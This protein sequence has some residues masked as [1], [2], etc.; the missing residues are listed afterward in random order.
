MPTPQYNFTVNLDDL[1][2]ILKQIKIAEASTNPLT[3]AIENLR[4]LVGSPLL[5]Y[6]LRTVDGSWNS[7]L[8]G[9]ER[10][11]AADNVMPRLV[12]GV[13]HNAEGRPVNLFGL[14][15]PGSAGSSY[16]QSNL[17]NVVYDSQPRL[18]SNLIVD[19]TASNP[20][21]VAAALERAANATYPGLETVQT[22]GNGTLFI[23]NQSPDIG[24]SA[25]FSGMMALFGQ[26]FDHGLDLLTK[27]GGTV[28]VPLKTDD[29]LYVEGSAT[30]FM[31]LSRA[32]NTRG[33]GQDGILGNADDD[34]R[35]HTNTTT[36]F[37]DQNQTYT[38][39]PSHQVFLREYAM[40][41]G[42]P[43]A[44]GDMLTGAH[45]IGNW[46]ELK[47]QAAQMLGICLLDADVGSVPLLATDRYGAFLRGPNG[48]VQVVTASGLIEGDPTANGGTGVLLPPNTLR[49]GHEFLVDIAHGAAPKAGLVAD[50]D[51]GIGGQPNP[52]FD[53]TQP[54][55]AANPLLLAQPAGTYDNELLD[56]HFITGDG[57]GNENIGLTAI[58]A[59]FHAEHNRLV[60]DYKNTI[61]ASGD[62]ALINEWLLT[63]VAAL[64]TSAAAIA[65]LQW[66]GERLF[67]A[68]R[69][70]TE[71]QYQHLVFEQFARAV[72]PSVDPFVFSNSADLD[73][74]IM[75]EF[76]NVVYRFGHSMLDENVA[77]MNNDLSS[78]DIGLIQAF[79]NPVEFTRN[80]A[81]T[82]HAAIGAIVRGMS[83]QV[84]NE[85]DEFVTEALRNN[86]VGLPLDLAVLNLARARETGAPSFN[87]ARAA[88]YAMTGDAQLAP[89]TSWADYAPHLKNPAS[90]INFIAAYGLHNSITSETTLE[91]KRAAATLMV[92]GD[93]DLNG[94]GL[95]NNDPTL[96]GPGY[97]LETAP[98]NRIDFLTGRGAWNAENSGLNKVD[99]WIGGLAEAKLEFGGMLG[100]TFNF[101]FEAQMESLQNGDRFY[102]LSR[103]QG[104][105]LLNELEP[106]T[107]SALIMRNSDLGDASS[108]THLPASIFA[109]PSYILEMNQAHQLTGIA[110]PNGMNGDPVRES[111]VLNALNPL[112]IRTA[113]GADGNGGVLSYAYDGPDHMVLGGSAGN[114]TLL[115]GRGMDTLWGDAGND[116]LDGGDE[117]D[118]VFGG[119]GDDIITDHGT[120]SGAADFLRGDNGNDVIS[121]GAGNDLVFGGAGQDFVIVGPDFTEVFAGRGNDFVLGGPGFDV[122]M[123]NEGDDW[124]EGGE[125]F[126]NLSGENSQLFFNSTIIGHDVL[127]GQG[128]DSDYDGESG[129][130]IMVQ[131]I[132]IQRNNGM[133]GFDW[134][135]HKGD[136]VAANSDLGIP[137]F[138]AQDVFTLRDRNDS[139]E[140]LSG[141][142]L[143]DVLSG[144]N[145]P[146]GA[147]GNPGGILNGPGS[148]S[149]LLQKNVSLINGLQALLGQPVLADHEAVVFDPRNGA[150]ILIGGLGSDRIMGRAGNDL[151]D[152]DAWLNVRVSVLSKTD[153]NVEIRSVDS[154]AA[155]RSEM[156]AG[157][158]NPGQL[159]IV[160]EIINNPAGAAADVD[161]AIYSDLRA[162][163][164][165]TR[166]LDGTWTVAHLRGTATDGTDTV[167]N[168][169]QLQFSDQVLNLTG[170]PAID[171][172]TPTEG[173]SLLAMPGSIL[174]FNGV[175]ATAVTYQWQ[176]GNG[177]TF[178]DIGGA[179]GLSFTPTQAQVGLQV[180]V[181]A[182]FTSQLGVPYSIASP[183]TG[184]VGDLAIGDSGDNILTGTAFDD[185]L[186]GLAGNDVLNGGLGTD[187]LLGGAGDDTYLIDDVDDLIV[188]LAGQGNDSVQ[189][190]LS[191]YILGN[192]L[193]NL[194]FSSSLN[195]IGTGN[196]LA[197]IISGGSGNDLLIGA[198]GNDTLVGALG[199]DTYLI[200]DTGDV[201]VEGAGAGTDLAQV[202]AAAYTLAANVEN[203]EYTGFANFSGTGNA[204]DNVISGGAGDDVLDGL[205]GNDTLVGDVGNDTLRGGLGD[206]LI[207]GNEGDDLIDGGAGADSMRG[208]VGDDRYQVDSALD[209]IDELAAE[210]EDSVTTTLATYTLGDFLENLAYAGAVAFTG[211]G[212]AQAN[213]ISGGS[214]ADLLDGAAGIDFMSGGQG[215]DTYVVDAALDVVNELAGQGTDLVRTNL[216]SYT[217][218]ANVENLSFTGSGMFV[219]VGNALANVITGGADGDVL[220]GDLGND[221]LIGGAGDDTYIVNSSTDLIVEEAGGGVDLVN[222]SALTYTLS[223]NVDN[224]AFTGTG[225]GTGNFIGTGN[226]LAN[227]LSGGAGNDTLNGAA[228][229]DS[230]AGGAG[231]DTYITDSSLDVVLELAAG[232]IDQVRTTALASTLAVNVEN[233]TFI[234][235][236]NFS[237]TGNATANILT[238]GA[239]NDI[240]N[241]LAGADTMN[242]LQ[243]NDTYIVD[244]TGDTPIEAAGAGIDTVHS[245]AL[246]YTLTTNVENLVF[247]GVGNFTGTGNV[248]ANSLTGGAGNDSLNGG[249]GIDTMAGGLGNDTYIVDSSA[250]L[251]TEAVGAGV[252]Q[253]RSSATSYTLAANVEN[254]TFIGAGN[255]SGT[256]NASPNILTGGA[257]ADIL[258]G[259]GGAD[260]MSGGLGNDTFVVDVS[261][262]AVLEAAGAGTDL[263]QSTA[264]LYTLGANVEN[265]T[266]T[267]AGNFTGNGNALANTVT[268]GAGNDTLRGLDGND[269]L[270]GGAGNDILEGGLGNDILV[271]A[272]G[273]G[274]DTV[275]GFDSDPLGGQDLLDLSALGITAATFAAR[276]QI[277]DTGTSLTVVVDG[278]GTFVL[279]NVASTA[280]LTTS[281]FILAA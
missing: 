188:E 47:A 69:F 123:G 1:A 48:F 70:V 11:G 190:T 178:V 156:L 29:P 126:D 75:E 193:E 121:N 102:Y 89:Y 8:P 101:V 9:M 222:S 55:T 28:F 255:F 182:S 153:P 84:G 233:M 189:T 224:L 145:F 134:A 133:L 279:Q 223:A 110:G 276:V 204:L 172:L 34:L 122:L 117:A 66:D 141:W 124:I 98:A 118:H 218:F 52:S 24:L 147:V 242:G 115:G 93:F 187:L 164:D 144:T 73:P 262:D 6:G 65:S 184:G 243:G 168:I 195:V 50:T 170:A 116:R 216:A 108:T 269:R 135:I 49:T 119:D 252:D 90:I 15:D 202:S 229:T 21:A 107:F 16:A 154:I 14:G 211:T 265:L 97:R 94:D 238:G 281:D 174:A 199:N 60:A 235:V 251:V 160:R 197:N 277:T 239:G 278:G 227:N 104:L 4:T 36:S 129:D 230:M 146:T 91:G 280:Q 173:Q 162:S 192:N 157:T 76:A 201:I 203:L 249:A 142:N 261:G 25:P 257:G 200:E 237:G 111:A 152:G 177:A 217:L 245:S 56:R 263:V 225:T 20:A 128:N 31:V 260:T 205:G 71:M 106:N 169:E 99:F 266:F 194:S 183:A 45:G 264:L 241:G 130:D 114:D 86:L 22:S 62:L 33:P 165:V 120:P 175:P 214:G 82:E 10:M 236:G 273:F 253:V 244:T 44:T 7:L 83:R 19:Q 171:D 180:R 240:L 32:V 228:G 13:F 219:G 40:V 234:G 27:G 85:I 274:T 87:E 272:S 17:G 226:A 150:D 38:S 181:V 63:D 186:Q 109:T 113:P 46:A 267:G 258:N 79:L 163:Y 92:M 61:L 250:D 215:N 81:T 96:V 139:V 58:H 176:S 167:R 191:S 140:G 259:L 136:P 207:N 196:A 270:Q 221:T 78:H 213:T 148:D 18:I 155:L 3:G 23:P 151:I 271:F 43:L 212:N 72:Q 105:N 42:K 210:G 67:Q 209:V 103:T 53:P 220:D 185:E 37:V 149:F 231:N 12:A 158:I 127:N 68:G 5:P 95:I 206:D 80:G 30:N 77:R 268:G 138:N 137:I 100:P 39:H 198:G 51:S 159:R 254:L 246:I 179:T 112:V 143:D 247:T 125:G 74:A 248:L 41:N 275:I 88:F 256:G 2:F 232:G 35:G 64:P 57:R 59:V 131:G 54:I 26:F 208:G 166:N 132:G 161:S